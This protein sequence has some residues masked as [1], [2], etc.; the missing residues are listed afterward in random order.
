VVT[1]QSVTD[2]AASLGF[3][4]VGLFPGVFSGSMQP[5]FPP[6]GDPSD[7]NITVT[8]TW[9]DEP[10]VRP[11]GTFT[12]CTL[13]AAETLVSTALCPLHKQDCGNKIRQAG[14]AI[15]DLCSI[16][17]EV[18]DSCR[19]CP[20][21]AD[22]SRGAG[23][24][25]GWCAEAEPEDVI[26][27]PMPAGQLILTGPLGGGR[28]IAVVGYQFHLNEPLEGMGLEFGDLMMV[29]PAPGPCGK[30]EAETR[31]GGEGISFPSD[32]GAKYAWP[33]LNHAPSGNYTL[34]WCR[35]SPGI[36]DCRVAEDFLVEAGQLTMEG[37]LLDQQHSCRSTLDCSV[38]VEWLQG[39]IPREGF[40][41]VVAGE[42][43]DG[44]TP[45][46]VGFQGGAAGPSLER[47][48]WPQLAATGGRRALCWC[49][50]P[51]CKNEAEDFVHQIG[52]LEV[53]G[54]YAEHEFS[55]YV[56]EECS[57]APVRGEGLGNGHTLLFRSHGTC[58]FTPN[59][60]EAPLL[61]GEVEREPIIAVSQA[62]D[63]CGVYF[64]GCTNAW[65][66]HLMGILP[67]DYRI[68]WCASTACNITDYVVDIGKLTV[69]PV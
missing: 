12:L 21:G 29:V 46:A 57:V 54:P 67:G 28:F 26:G 15:G 18:A 49:A 68:C 25:W 58:A 5:P 35:I 59:A 65:E 33:G 39:A 19:W 24:A 60:T 14:A 30:A 17:C 1:I 63:Q 8:Y 43:C 38:D 11:G 44:A 27:I 22:H 16:P 37:P 10:I 42:R 9:G 51:G 53:E 36:T 50:L 61:P 41:A 20:T 62:A 64:T 34:C 55:C 45:F 32:D 66:A 23:T 6:N 31:I 3:P 7:G 69:V 2:L 52:T 40:L 48:Q 4:A 13:P 56:G 47:F